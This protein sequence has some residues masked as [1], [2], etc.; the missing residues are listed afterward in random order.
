MSSDQLV[1]APGELRAVAEVLRIG[2]SYVLCEWERRKPDFA[3]NFQEGTTEP[4]RLV[5]PVPQY[6]KGS[7]E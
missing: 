3:E 5:A 4:R 2:R 6:T 7:S 1:S